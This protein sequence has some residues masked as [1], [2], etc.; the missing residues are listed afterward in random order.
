MNMAREPRLRAEQR[1][2]PSQ[3]RQQVPRGRP[4]SWSA[5]C[6]GDA[7][8]ASQAIGPDEVVLN[9]HLNRRLIVKLAYPIVVVAFV[10]NGCT[11]Q[12]DT[13]RTGSGDRDKPIVKAQPAPG[14]GQEV[15]REAHELGTP[16]ADRL[17]GLLHKK[18]LLLS[19]NDTASPSRFHFVARVTRRAEGG[20]VRST[21]VLVG[22]AGNDVG[23]LC[24]S[25]GGLAYCY[26]TNSLLVMVDHT[27]PGGL[28]ISGAGNLAF[29]LASDLENDRL[30][31]TL[32]RFGKLAAP[33]VV[34][35]LGSLLRSTLRK[36]EDTQYDAANR[37]LNVHTRQ[38]L[39]RVTLPPEGDQALPFQ[40]FVLE[41]TQTEPAF[42]FWAW[43]SMQTRHST[44]SAS[45]R[46]W[47]PV[48][49]CRSARWRR[50][51]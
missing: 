36:M 14:L 27:K 13:G 33:S 24:T 38:A 3:S 15:P 12:P 46:R 42:Q 10:I 34:L 8:L 45:R 21:D 50:V 11:E 35:D 31:F 40:D 44:C 28:V 7:I 49:V 1:R 4:L 20:S 32:A 41:N 47:L 22:R 26:L 19:T 17:R 5:D 6:A 23:V 30:V 2:R 9:G 18:V 39:V 43:P 25:P 29:R 48:S 51:T 37:T 16:A